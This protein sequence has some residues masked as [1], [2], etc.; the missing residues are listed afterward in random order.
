M[1]LEKLQQLQ[2][3]FDTKNQQL[4]EEYIINLISNVLLYLLIFIIVTNKHLG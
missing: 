1:W 3:E 2:S 4:I